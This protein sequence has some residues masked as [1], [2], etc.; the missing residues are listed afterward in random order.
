MAAHTIL[1]T[2]SGSA[3][4]LEPPCCLEGHRTWHDPPVLPPRGAWTTGPHNHPPNPSPPR[5]LTTPGTPFHPLAPPAEETKLCST[6][7]STNVI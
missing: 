4:L 7:V 6:V 5:L 2:T 1:F 3:T